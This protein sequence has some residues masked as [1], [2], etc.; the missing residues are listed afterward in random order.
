VIFDRVEAT[1]ASYRKD[2]LIHTAHKP[3]IFNK[4]IRADHGEGR[5]FCRT[6]LPTDAVLTAVGGAGKEFW[7]V[8][9]NWSIVSDGLKGE[10]LALM[11]QW[12]LEVTPGSPR[13]NDVFLHVIQVG[14]QQLEVMDD[15]TLLKEERMCGVRLS[16]AGR[17]WEVIFNSTGKPGGHIRRFGGTGSINKTLAT[18]ADSR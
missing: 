5:M 14:S 17:T 10:N 13:R 8:G 16:A 12:R 18:S 7:S 11:G 2:W 1:D 6:L 15:A 3:I 4:T 9:K